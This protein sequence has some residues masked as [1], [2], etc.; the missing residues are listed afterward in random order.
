MVL[1]QTALREQ[2]PLLISQALIAVEEKDDTEQGGG[3]GGIDAFLLE[4]LRNGKYSKTVGTGLNM[5]S[6]KGC[7][8]P[9][10]IGEFYQTFNKCQIFTYS[11]KN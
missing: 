2:P 11:S 9:D 6:S 5:D 7:K 8:A 4:S 1:L 10:A 3:G